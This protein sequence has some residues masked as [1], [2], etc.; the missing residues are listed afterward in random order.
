MI[1]SKTKGFYTEEFVKHYNGYDIYKVDYEKLNGYKV[2][3]PATYSHCSF[4]MSD[5]VFS[6]VSGCENWIDKM[7]K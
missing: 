1:K 3:K 7:P 5:L 6:D 4:A 2:F